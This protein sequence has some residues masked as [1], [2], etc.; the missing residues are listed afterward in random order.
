MLDQGRLVLATHA[1]KQTSNDSDSL[2]WN[3]RGITLLY[4]FMTALLY[5]MLS[6]TMPRIVAWLLSI[7]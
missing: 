7:Y 3:Y 4:K 6:V 2:I 1:W 5:M